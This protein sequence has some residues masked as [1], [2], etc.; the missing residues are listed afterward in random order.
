[1]G[2]L[3]PEQDKIISEFLKH[4]EIQISLRGDND[5]D[6]VTCHLV[7]KTTK[8]KFGAILPFTYLG[9]NNG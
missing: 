1:M 5:T 9:K 6:N 4:F 7:T 3:P 8:P 2:R